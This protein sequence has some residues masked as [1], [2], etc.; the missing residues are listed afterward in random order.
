MAVGPRVNTDPG[1]MIERT[2]D[3]TPRIVITGLGA[4]CGAGLTVEAIWNA[5]Q[6]GK[7]A[8]APITHWDASRWPIQ[9]AA[10][11]TGVSDATLVADRKYHKFLS[12]TD[13]FGLYA[14][15]IALQQSGLTSHRD[16]MDSASAALFNDRSGVFV[17]SGGGAYQN[18]YDFFPALT[19]AGGDLRAFGREIESCVNP[20]WLLTRL[21]N[22]VLCYTGIRH[23]FKGTNACITNQ[24]AGG[25]LAIAEA[26]AAIRSGE[27]DRAV[28]TGHDAPIEPETLLYYHQAG[29]LSQDV[30]RPFDWGRTGTILGEGAASVVLEKESDARARQ[31]RVCGEFLGS[32]CTTEATGIVAVRPDGDGLSRAIEMA[33]ADANLQSDRVGLVVAHGNGTLASDASEAKAIRRVFGKSPPPVAAFKWAVGHALAASGAL[34]VVLALT[35]LEQGVVP[36]IATLDCLDPELAPLPVSREPQRPRSDIALVLNRGFGGMNVALVVRA[37]GA[38]T[39]R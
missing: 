23:S 26:A 4:V 39:A 37:L 33:L 10:E 6:Q 21:P 22:N 12:R 30:L 7:S 25:A 13:L 19:A 29:L 38:D 8:I 3:A 11:I 31:A 18:S 9:Q 5:V 15:D 17:G 16:R 36:G 2:F 24:C 32:G 34:D 14:T 20:M 27:A 1:I 35:A 28:A